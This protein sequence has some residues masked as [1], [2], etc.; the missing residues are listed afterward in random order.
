[1]RYRARRILPRPIFDFADG[2]TEEEYTLRRN[3]HAFRDIALLP[4][5]LLGAATFFVRTSD[6]ESSNTVLRR[7]DH[8]G[9]GLHK[10]QRIV[11]HRRLLLGHSERH[12]RW[13][14]G[15]AG[16]HTRHANG[17][18]ISR[19]PGHASLT[20]LITSLS[21]SDPYGWCADTGAFLVRACS[22]WT[23]VGFGISGDIRHCT[24]D[25]AREYQRD[26]H[27]DRRPAIDV[28]TDAYPS[29]HIHR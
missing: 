20:K 22:D 27:D 23:T 29:V 21:W 2:A 1:M 15:T 13:R 19:M 9:R 11:V 16:S 18:L 10:W 3:E 25:H 14:V 7:A 5:P 4:R 6:H 24:T 26:S 8:P 17:S 12:E 28:G